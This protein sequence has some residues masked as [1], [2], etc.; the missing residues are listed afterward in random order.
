VHVTNHLLDTLLNT[1]FTLGYG[2]L[3]NFEARN[4]FVQEPYLTKEGRGAFPPVT[5]MVFFY[6]TFSKSPVPWNV[7]W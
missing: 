5:R 7:R 6:V 4:T 2:V 1:S 3:P